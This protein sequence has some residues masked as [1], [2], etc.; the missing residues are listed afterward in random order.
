MGG[1]RPAPCQ[2]STPNSSSIKPLAYPKACMLSRRPW[3]VVLLNTPRRDHEP[4]PGWTGWHRGR[5]D[6]Q[7]YL[8]KAISVARE[9]TGLQK[10]DKSHISPTSP[11]PAP[12]WPRRAVSTF[13]CWLCDGGA[14]VEGYLKLLESQRDSSPHPK[15]L[16]F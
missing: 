9:P 11:M 14:S 4:S 6:P 2:I 13:S 16:G 5:G 3:A 7:K 8:R 1:P 12:T 10:P 15:R